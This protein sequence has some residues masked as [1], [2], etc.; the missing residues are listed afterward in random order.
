MHIYWWYAINIE[1]NP[2]ILKI[3]AK[4][5][6]AVQQNEI[7]HLDGIQRRIDVLV[8]VVYHQYLFEEISLESNR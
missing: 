3:P 7:G 6:K 8:S 5:G 2:L 4:N 1:K